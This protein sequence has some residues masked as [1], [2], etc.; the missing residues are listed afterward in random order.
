MAGSDWA[1]APVTCHGP[2]IHIHTY[3]VTCDMFLSLFRRVEERRKKNLK[4]EEE[5]KLRGAWLAQVGP[6]H[7]HVSQL[8]EGGGGEDGGAR[9][10]HRWPA[11]PARAH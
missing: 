5:K 11:M 3:T 9:D 7:C 4:K 8:G 6:P 10:D 2:R 1:S